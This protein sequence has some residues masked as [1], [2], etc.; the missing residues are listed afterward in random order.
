MKNRNIPACNAVALWAG[1]FATLL[2][3]L[4]FLALSP[5]AQATPETALPNFNTADGDHALFS[6]TTGAANTAIGWFSLFSDTAGSFNT[7]TGAGTLLFN[8]A[9]NNAAFGTAALL[10]NTDGSDNTAV[11]TAT[12][13]NNTASGNTA[14]GSRALV[15]NTTGGTLGNISGFDVGPN[16]AVGQEALESNTIAG[17]NTA[18]GYQ[19]LQ[20]FTTGPVGFE[21][22]GLCTAV[23]FQALANATGTDG[24]SAFGYRA[25]FDNTDGYSNTAVGIN[26][27]VAN[28]TGAENTANGAATLV[29]NINGIQNTA[30]GASALISNADGFGNT[31]IGHQALFFNTSGDDNTVLGRSAGSGVTTANNV[32]CIGRGVSGENVSDSCYIGNIFGSTSSG[33]IG[34]FVN[35]LGKLG[36]V[37]SSRRFKDEIKPMDKASEAIL[38]LE[39]VTF[40]YKKDFD[41]S[42]TT[43]F[44]LVAEEVEKVNPD[45]VVHDK[46]GKPYSV[47]YDQVNAMLLNEFLKEHKKVEEQQTTI[48]ELKSTVAQQQK[49]MD[50]LVAHI[51][52]QDSKI[53]RVSDQVEMS[54]AAPKVVL[55]NP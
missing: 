4:G 10:F 21:Q 33:G 3:A 49:G 14:V 35:S 19:A 20:S 8:N 28:T 54:K 1:T 7:A 9:D 24:N 17:A 43:Q 13:L 2:L 38:A 25:L 15:N 45:L 12:L 30:N 39:P 36:T 41:P 26:A 46:E 48:A 37:T 42:G 5:V 18:L 16:V 11:G 23:G 55:N 31:A 51:K 47:R 32:I 27:L 22:V 44:G 53:E 50:A 6:V 40:R 52:E 29:H 34:V